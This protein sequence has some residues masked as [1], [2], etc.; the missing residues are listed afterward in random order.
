[1]NVDD[2]KKPATGPIEELADFYEEVHA[3]AMRS[4]DHDLPQEIRE[5]IA[6]VHTWAGDLAYGRPRAERKPL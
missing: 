3:L 2:T 4:A 6:T 5:R 1:M